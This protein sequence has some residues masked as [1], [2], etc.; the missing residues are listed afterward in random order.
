MDISSTEFL[1]ER[2]LPMLTI[3]L[4]ASMR[5]CGGSLMRMIVLVSLF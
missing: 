1:M 4:V 3:V 2:V 5:V